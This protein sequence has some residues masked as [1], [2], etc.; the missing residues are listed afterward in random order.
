[1]TTKT[2]A[3]PAVETSQEETEEYLKYVIKDCVFNITVEYGGT[4]IMQTGKP[5]P[6]PP[7]PH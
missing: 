2:K 1:M 3:I 5:T 7:P 4:L 6:P